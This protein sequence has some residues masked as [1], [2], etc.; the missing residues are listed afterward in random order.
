MS[1]NTY[2]RPN[3]HQN[4]PEI[5]GVKPLCAGQGELTHTLVL[6]KSNF[7]K[8]S[9]FGN[10]TSNLVLKVLNYS[11]GTLFL[12][13]KHKIGAGFCLHSLIHPGMGQVYGSILHG[14]LCRCAAQIKTSYL[15]WDPGLN[16]SLYSH[17]K[18]LPQ[19]LF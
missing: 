4:G 3:I 2:F 15:Y 19:K 9:I 5:L 10:L 7:W 18:R 8:L 17:V 13:N 6:V 16:H 1:I 14:P 12:I 11:N